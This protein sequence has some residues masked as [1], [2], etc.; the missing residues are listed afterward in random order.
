MNTIT[1]ENVNYK[2]E[3]IPGKGKCLVPEKKLMPDTLMAGQVFKRISAWVGTEYGVLVT[4][5]NAIFSLICPNSCNRWTDFIAVTPRDKDSHEKFK[6]ELIRCGWE[7]QPTMKSE[8][9]VK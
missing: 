8:W 3:E 4:G 9:T 1:V 5:Y 7:Y 2:F 6:Q